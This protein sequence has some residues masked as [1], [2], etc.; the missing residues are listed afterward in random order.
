MHIQS[1]TS[2]TVNRDAHVN[3]ILM[4]SIFDCSLAWDFHSAIMYSTR[5]QMYAMPGLLLAFSMFRCVSLYTNRGNLRAKS[6]NIGRFMTLSAVVAVE[7]V[8]VSRLLNAMHKG[9]V[10]WIFLQTPTGIISMLW[11]TFLV[12]FIVKTALCGFIN[13]IG[14]A[15]WMR[16]FS[17]W[18]NTIHA[19]K[20]ATILAMVLLHDFMPLFLALMMIFLASCSP[21]DSD[22]QSRFSP[23]EWFAILFYGVSPMAIAMFGGKMFGYS[24]R[25]QYS[26]FSLERILIGAISLSSVAI[27]T[28][29]RPSNHIVIS[30]SNILRI[31][32]A[33]AALLGSFFGFNFL[34]PFL[35][36]LLCLGEYILSIF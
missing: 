6:P 36:A 14:T 3:G 25:N 4:L 19:L 35:V 30:M 9:T 13:L 23:L 24:H 31:F 33:N 15:T 18:F 34:S 1:G 8:A 27:I 12:D 10:P 26:L 28:R 11:I 32:G 2:I 20:L 16:K 7:A 29:K 22:D 21:V 17:T 5:H